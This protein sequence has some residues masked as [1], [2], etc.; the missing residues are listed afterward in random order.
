M[1]FFNF[2]NC[3][4]MHCLAYEMSTSIHIQ[5]VILDH[6]YIVHTDAG[7]VLNFSECCNFYYRV[8]PKRKHF[9]VHSISFETTAI[10]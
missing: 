5:V 1:Y 10:A 4:Q 2:K 7:N 6:F 9:I 3:F 8:N